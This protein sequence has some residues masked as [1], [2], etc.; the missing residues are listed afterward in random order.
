MGILDLLCA[1]EIVTKD[2]I[3]N[4][5]R[6]E[7]LGF[8]FIDKQTTEGIIKIL[9]D[10]F[11][12][13]EIDDE[14]GLVSKKE[15]LL[16]F[17]TELIKGEETYSLY[18]AF[19]NWEQEREILSALGKISKS[20]KEKRELNEI[21]SF[22]TPVYS[23]VP[24]KL[25]LKAD[26]DGINYLELSTFRKGRIEVDAKIFNISMKELK[27]LYNVTA[28]YLFKQNVRVGIENKK[29]GK[30]LKEE[31]MNYLK[32]GLIQ[33]SNSKSI[34]FSRYFNLSETIL[35]E[36]RP[37]I[38]WYKHNGINIFM[39]TE[40]LFDTETDSVIINPKKV[41]VING[42]QTLTNFFIAK[43]ELV[44]E[45]ETSDLELNKLGILIDDILDSI[46]VKTIFIKGREDLSKTI[47]WGLNNQI[48]I[49]NQDFV[50]VSDAVITLNKLLKTYQ[51]RIV[52]TGE[53]ETIY[54]GL[55]PLEFI[56]AY[57]IVKYEPGTSKNFNK[58]ILDEEIELALSDIQN[59]KT[60]LKKIDIALE[61]G[62][63]WNDYSKTQKDN[64]SLF[65]R[66]GKNYFQ[67]F[68]IHKLDE[69]GDLDSLLDDDLNMYFE[70]LDS[71]LERLNADINNYK[72][73]T[74]FDKVIKET[75]IKNNEQITINEDELANYINQN[76]KNN[77]SISS[78]IKKYNIENST[79]I[80][81]FRT[82]SYY[83]QSG[84]NN[85]K[86]K[87]HFPLPNS[88]FE[89]FYK[90]DGYE[91]DD[92]YPTFSES[93][94]YEELKKS[95]PVYIIFLNQK[96]EV[97]K[98]KFINVFSIS[99]AEGWSQKAEQ[100]FN[101]TRD[102]FIQGDADLFPKVSSQIGFHIRPKAA[103][104]NDTF[105]FSNGEDITRRTFWVNSNYIQQILEKDNSLSYDI[106]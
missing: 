104:G 16:R 48:P 78:V 88:T 83:A 57:Y 95:Y 21:Y 28:K 90:R 6:K 74:L 15:N 18:I 13:I 70:E 81:Y 56:K 33:I 31:F 25:P 100:A 84:N 93:L 96:K 79:D 1:D 17:R 101:E 41:S 75:S 82:I 49:T 5:P 2:D 60:I 26:Q 8:H 39:D 97:L 102:A 54:T 69:T 87:E 19:S 62:I 61:V 68:V 80:K 30:N 66:Y 3:E 86:I 23:K 76:K 51:L 20:A 45:L 40:A 73:D 36:Y 4:S 38:F 91:K 46:I 47:T 53:V 7:C 67:S 55:T 24:E 34:D 50:A 72:S 98:V 59:N 85:G 22:M 105:T 14:L 29:I 64:P 52:K 11:S 58:A 42:A 44:K 35:E 89:E 27:K 106:S 71:V 92:N 9:F 12:D 10:D 94:L 103:N 63:W 77:Y 65:L 43:E 99:N 37:D 32:V